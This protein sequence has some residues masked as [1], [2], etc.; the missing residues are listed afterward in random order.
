MHGSRELAPVVETLIVGGGL[1]GACVAFA[2]AKR[3]H[4]CTIVEQRPRL[5]QGASGNRVALLMPYITASESPSHAIYSAGFEFSLRLITGELQ[6]LMTLYQ[7]GALQL[8]STRRFSQLLTGS[9]PLLDSDHIRRIS[10]DE[11]SA[12]S[13]VKISS[14]AFFCSSAGYLSPS[15]FVGACTTAHPNK[16]S[17][18]IDTQARQILRHKDGWKVVLSD[19]SYIQ[20]RIVVVCSAFEAHQLAT[21]SWLPLEAIRGQTAAIRSSAASQNLRTIVCFDGYLTPADNQEHMLGAHYRH[22]DMCNTPSESDTDD[23]VHRVTRWLPDLHIQRKDTTSARV[24]F[25][26]STFDRL[27]YVG[28]LS[29]FE[30]MRAAACNYQPGSNLRERIPLQHAP[31]LFVSLGHGSRGLLSCPIA[32]EIIARKICGEG[33]A[34]LTQASV[35][36]HPSRV[37]FRELERCV[38]CASPSA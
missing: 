12:L 38:R 11:A 30:A 23:M 8:P 34:E 22:N 17:S 20:S 33:L 28:E 9:Q 19:G 2:L 26:T 36:L 6:G 14:A 10:R 4:R 7:S 15:S 16:V 37:V 25:R 31:G 21:T 3:G 29:D 35:D 18:L 32:G 5:S 13:G 27:P 24:C 1:A